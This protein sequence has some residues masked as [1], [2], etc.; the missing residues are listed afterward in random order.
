MVRD[1]ARR[2][3]FRSGLLTMKN[4]EKKNG[5]TSGTQSDRPCS[6]TRIIQKEPRQSWKRSGFRPGKG[7]P[8]ALSL[9]GRFFFATRNEILTNLEI[10]VVRGE[11]FGRICIPGIDGAYRSGPF[12]VDAGPGRISGLP[13]PLALGT[14]GLEFADRALSVSGIGA[15]SFRETVEDDRHHQRM[16]A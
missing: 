6:T 1:F 12:V 15:G 11:S 13:A 8:S 5:E 4:H 2:E 9:S 14:S 3:D 10:R 16:Q 7:M